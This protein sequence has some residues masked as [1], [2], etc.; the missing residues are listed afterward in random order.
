MPFLTAKI[1]LLGIVVWT[2]NWGRWWE[3]HAL[4]ERVTEDL[5]PSAPSTTCQPHYEA[6]TCPHCSCR[7]RTPESPMKNHRARETAEAQVHPRDSDPSGG[8]HSPVLL[9]L[10][11]PWAH[12]QVSSEQKQWALSLGWGE[13][14]DPLPRLL[15]SLSLWFIMFFLS[16]FFPW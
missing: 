16:L 11:P 7:C 1:T 9:F 12:F 3:V 8:L 2:A 13:G 15:I 6:A 4:G 5:L 14:G 10:D